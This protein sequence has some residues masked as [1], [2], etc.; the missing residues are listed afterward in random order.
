MMDSNNALHFFLI[1]VERE[2]LSDAVLNLVRRPSEIIGTQ[3]QPKNVR[4][5][6]FFNFDWYDDC[7]KK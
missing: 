4:V 3:G 7:C 6:V 5:H 2:D 1:F